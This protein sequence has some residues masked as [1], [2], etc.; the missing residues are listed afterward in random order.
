MKQRGKIFIVM[1]IVLIILIYVFGKKLIHKEAGI[2]IREMEQ[3]WIK[4]L[5]INLNK[6]KEME[7]LKKTFYENQN[8][9]N[10]LEAERL[11]I[12]NSIIDSDVK[13]RIE[14]LRIKHKI[15]NI[16]A[17][18]FFGRREFMKILFPYL[19]SNLKV[20]GGILDKIILCEHL[21]G[22]EKKK[23]K[24]YLTRFMFS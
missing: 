15:R 19:D 22:P 12:K 4:N 14:T 6:I 13:V 3:Q 16:I 10:E 2:I 1:G 5:S 20:N 11:L 17:Y 8:K 9:I 23:N 7:E 21:L 24:E 18:V